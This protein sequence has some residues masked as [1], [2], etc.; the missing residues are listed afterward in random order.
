MKLFAPREQIHS[1]LNDQLFYSILHAGVLIS[2]SST[3]YHI[4]YSFL[5]YVEMKVDVH[6]TVDDPHLNP[7]E[8][9]LLVVD[10]K[11]KLHMKVRIIY[12]WKLLMI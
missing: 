3:Y 5:L 4:L 1:R 2:M 6:L 12:P 9:S 11:V 8:E 10:I 7:L